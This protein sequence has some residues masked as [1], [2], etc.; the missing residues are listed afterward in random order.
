M[1]TT[2]SPAQHTRP[3]PL[4][5][6]SA[7]VCAAVAVLSGC[8]APGSNSNASVE[9]RVEASI[10]LVGTTW[11]GY[12]YVP[13]YASYDGIGYWTDRIDAFSFCT[14]WFAST[15]G[16]I[17]TAGHCVDPE[18]GRTAVLSQYLNDE[19]APDLLGDAIV[20]WTVEGETNG[21]DVERTV[22]V[23]QPDG[24]DGAVIDDPITAQIVDYRAFTDGDL[25]LLHVTGID[26]T[27]PLAIAP[28]QPEVGDDLT[29]IGFP[30][31][32]LEVVDGARIR[33][34]F[35]SGT[36]SSQQ[37]STSGVAGTEIN[38][39]IS[40]GMSGGPTIDAQGQV[41]GINSYTI[42]GESRNFNFI[43]GTED[44]GAFLTKNGVDYTA[45]KK[46]DNGGGFN[47]LGILISVGLFLLLVAVIVVVVIVLVLRNGRKNQTVAPGAT[48]STYVAAPPAEATPV[49][50][51]DGH[52]TAAPPAEP[53]EPVVEEP[54]APKTTFCSNCG[55]ALS[56]DQKFCSGCGAP[57]PGYAS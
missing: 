23:I 32:V 13:D 30:A 50:D 35:K 16:H 5:A 55:A 56:P 17:V 25:A 27:P 1:L 15:D 4:V 44:L 18:E 28:S 10:L 43:T 42:N 24:V 8:A 14:G 19:G 7:V 54:T 51:W 33:A 52:S 20:G 37:V 47:V 2:L 45:G 34:S 38:A 39:D 48:P 31:T 22:Q 57:N 41:L 12:I 53:V 49:G 6:L 26:P 9:S 29:A 40:P 36:A 21:T 3:K 11:S 46:E